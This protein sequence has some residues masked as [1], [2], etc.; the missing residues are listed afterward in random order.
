MESQDI[1]RFQTFAVKENEIQLKT[2]L[3][4]FN[5]QL[6]LHNYLA[7]WQNQH[8]KYKKYRKEDFYFDGFMYN[9]KQS[10]NSILYVFDYKYSDRQ[11][12]RRIYSI[13]DFISKHSIDPE[14]NNSSISYLILNKTNSRCIK[15]L[16]YVN[17]FEKNIIEE[18]ALIKPTMIICCGCY[19]IVNKMFQ[20]YNKSEILSAIKNIPLLEM[21]PSTFQIKNKMFQLHFEYVYFK[22]FGWN[23]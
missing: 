16:D 10:S 1:T 9:L 20:K 17:D 7:R 15:T 5:I 2:C 11:S 12:M 13:Q 6:Q 8:R 14:I 21:L 19:D 23:V 18:I 3:T 22:Q 4:P